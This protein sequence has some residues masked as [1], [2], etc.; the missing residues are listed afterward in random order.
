[1]HLGNAGCCGRRRKFFP[2]L[3][4]TG[5]LKKDVGITALHAYDLGTA[6]RVRNCGLDERP[7][8]QGFNDMALASN[9]DVYV[10]NSTV[11]SVAGFPDGLAAPGQ[12]WPRSHILRSRLR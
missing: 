5:E 6:K 3:I 9:G 2:D 7:T 11:N 4:P 1:V 8:M 10:S 12:A